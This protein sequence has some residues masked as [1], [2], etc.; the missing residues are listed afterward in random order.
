MKSTQQTLQEEE[1]SHKTYRDGQFLYQNRK[2]TYE[3]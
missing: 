1:A 3:E 2:I